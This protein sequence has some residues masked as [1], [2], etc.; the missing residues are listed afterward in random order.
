MLGLHIAAIVLVLTIVY[1]YSKMTT[2][3]YSEEKD[4]ETRLGVFHT[5]KQL[6][7]ADKG[8]TPTNASK[9]HRQG[10]SL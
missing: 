4:T 2:S 5:E 7:I 1:R 10:I 9:A 6:E 3:H 8:N